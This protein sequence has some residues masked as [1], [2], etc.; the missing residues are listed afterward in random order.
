MAE[1]PGPAVGGDGGDRRPPAARAAV[2]A[3]EERRRAGDLR[4]A[5]DGLAAA[6]REVPDVQGEVLL[7]R[8]RHELAD[9]APIPRPV[10]D[11][12]PASVDPFPEV[13]GRTPEVPRS[14]LSVD[15]LRGGIAHHGALLVRGLLDPATVERLAEGV[16]R[17][18]AGAD[19]WAEG[20]PHGATAPWFVPFRAPG[21]RS[22]G[23]R[24]PWVRAGGAVWGADAPRVLAW[25]LDALADSGLLGVIGRHLGEVPLVSVNKLALRRVGADANPTWHQD[26]SFMG[27]VRAVNVWVALTRCGPGTDAPG[28]DL[29]PGRLDELVEVGTVGS[30]IQHAV[31]PELVA[32]L[33][34]DV[35]VERPVFE[36]GDALLFDER[37]LHRTGVLPGQATPRR[38]IECWTFAPSSFPEDY[39]ALAI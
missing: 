7:V 20:A 29:V 11:W 17:A 21:T 5:V 2:R 16:D 22:L 13:V 12:P 23:N 37:F 9:A 4:G 15:A 28:L 39:V 24:R 6:V 8:L 35:G 18:F 30:R 36:P 38:A 25:L 31:S 26:G 34:D 1:S 10:G 27:E 19:A 32:E 33:V 3:A 14:A